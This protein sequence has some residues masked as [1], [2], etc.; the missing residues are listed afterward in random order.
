MSQDIDAALKGW[1]FRPGV[2]QARLVQAGDGRQVSQMR[3]DLGL[4]QIETTGRPDGTPATGS[5]ESTFTT[6]QAIAVRARKSGTGGIH[7]RPA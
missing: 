2:V 7:A 3:V 1:D 6:S 4:L 5:S